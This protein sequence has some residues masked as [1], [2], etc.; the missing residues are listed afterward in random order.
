MA[1]FITANETLEQRHN[2]SI[3]RSFPTIIG[4]LLDEAGGVHCGRVVAVSGTT[5]TE[6]AEPTTAAA[7]ATAYGFTVYS[8]MHEPADLTDGTPHYGDNSMVSIMTKGSMYV[9]CEGTAVAGRPVLVRH[10]SDGGSNTE[11]GKVS[12]VSDYPAGGIVA[13]PVAV[14][15]ND[16]NHYSITL[17]DGVVRE[18]YSFN[19]D[20]T[21][22]AQ[23]LVEGLAALINAGTAFDAT[24]DNSALSITSVTGILEVDGG[25]QFTLTNP[26][27][28]AILPGAYFTESRTGAG[29]VEINF[30]RNGGI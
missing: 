5:N 23:E 14:V 16:S 19:T 22:T 4:R 10:T 30:D 27:R 21:P 29:L 9:D 7:V 28:C 12:A 2:G 11:L 26:A 17:Y 13:T 20:V 1:L 15:A 8:P 24:E 18:T 3:S 25:A 6:C